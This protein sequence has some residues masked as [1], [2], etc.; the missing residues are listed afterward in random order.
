MKKISAILL[1]VY[2]TAGCSS[3]GG[4]TGGAGGTGTSS[5]ADGLLLSAFLTTDGNF[6]V[7]VIQNGCFDENGEPQEP[8][9]GLT[10]AT[11]TFTITVADVADLTGGLFP[12]GIT[13][14]S[15]TVS[16]APAGDTATPGLSSRTFT[17]V[18]TV[19]TSTATSAVT[20]I[21]A[22]VG[23]TIPQFATANG[24]PVRSYQVTVTYRGRQVSGEAVTLVASTFMEFGNFDRCS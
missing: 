14:E 12:T 2:L 15:Y 13:L 24:A 9:P 8:E 5:T 4:T 7:D 20:V 6:S 3:G 17:Q 11:G 22:D 1:A 16:F 18:V 10:T 21:L 19:L 23:F